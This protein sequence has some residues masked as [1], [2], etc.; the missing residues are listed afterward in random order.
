MDIQVVAQFYQ[1]LDKSNLH[2]LAEVYHHDVVFEDAAH[3][4]EG[5]ALLE[6]YFHSLYE[7]VERCQ[8]TIHTMHQADGD[9]FLA[10]TMH[11][12]HPKLSGGKQIDVRGMTH[13]QFSEHKVIY[14]RDYFD[15]G[16]MLYEHLPLLGGL[17]R[18][19]KRRL[20]K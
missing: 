16:E 15:L 13:L 6:D 2:L 20:G 18:A 11:L 1:K 3:R 7:N 9:G 19:I 4:I 14:H 12:Q 17:I 8:F 10:W 5:L